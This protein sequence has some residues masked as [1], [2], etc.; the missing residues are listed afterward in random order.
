LHRPVG[1]DVRTADVIDG[2]GDADEALFLQALIVPPLQ[3]GR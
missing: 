2:V 3:R 1:G